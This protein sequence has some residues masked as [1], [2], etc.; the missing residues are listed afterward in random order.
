LT[1]V[2]GKF[3]DEAGRL[4]DNDLRA[5]RPQAVDFPTNIRISPEPIQMPAADDGFFD[6]VFA[7]IGEPLPDKITSPED[8]ALDLLFARDY[9]VR[10]VTWNRMLD[11]KYGRPSVKRGVAR[12]AESSD[13]VEVTVRHIGSPTYRFP[14]ETPH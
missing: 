1:A 12:G 3:R 5:G 6:R 10:S 9:Q 11:H 13:S 7:R 4:A 2:A 8:Y 14:T